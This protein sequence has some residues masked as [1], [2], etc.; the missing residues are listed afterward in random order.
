MI[1]TTI[2]RITL[3]RAATVY[4]P[5]DTK[6]PLV[7]GLAAAFTAIII[8]FMG[9]RIYIRGYRMRRSW[10]IDDTMFILSS[11]FTIAQCVA[12]QLSASQGLGAHLWRLPF[13]TL[14]RFTVYSFVLVLAYN[15]SFSFIKATFLLQH[16]RAFGL[17]SIMRLCDILL[18]IML[19]IS[20]ALLIMNGVAMKSY[21]AGNLLLTVQNIDK[22]T[23]VTYITAGA[24][25][26]SDIVIFILPMVVLWPVRVTKTQ[27]IGLYASFGVGVFTIVILIFKIVNISETFSS[28]DPSYQ[29]VTATV[30]AIAEPTSA[31]VFACAPFIRPLLQRGGASKDGSH[32]SSR[33]LTSTSGNQADPMRPERSMQ[34][35]SPE[36]LSI[37]TS[38]QMVR[39]IEAERSIDGDIEDYHAALFV[40]RRGNS[41]NPFTTQLSSPTKD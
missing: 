36:C 20:V 41:M 24:H 40:E 5:T 1:S 39:I 31:I 29:V 7:I 11:I 32:S 19:L 17:P 28:P 10:K 38:P 30:L 33:H 18:G 2:P 12:V 26:V 6:Q 21:L 23:T 9:I 37:P 16:R 3:E 22:I 15:I 25:L 13:S 35:Q 14:T 8:I 4:L 27:K 34:P